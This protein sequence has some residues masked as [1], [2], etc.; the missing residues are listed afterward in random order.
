MKQ[1]FAAGAYAFERRAVSQIPLDELDAARNQ[2]LIMAAWA[3]QCPDR[4]AFAKQSAKYG[5]SNETARTCKQHIC[6][7]FHRR[8]PEQR[9]RSRLALYSSIA[10]TLEPRASQQQRRD[11]RTGHQSAHSLS[12]SSVSVGRPSSRRVSR[13]RLVLPSLDTQA[14]AVCGTLRPTASMTTR[15]A[16]NRSA[17][18]AAKRAIT[19]DSISAVNAPDRSRSSARDALVMTGTSTRRWVRTRPSEWRKE[20]MRPKYRLL[21]SFRF[22]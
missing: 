7:F 17:F 20:A 22:G 10:R 21:G 16:T 15:K 11:L 2:I 13:Q 4:V 19:W 8:P 9:R 5:R 3:D 6:G 1:I 14:R 12:T 18:A